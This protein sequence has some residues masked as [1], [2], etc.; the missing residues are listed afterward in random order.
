MTS[1]ILTRQL[2]SGEGTMSS[3]VLVLDDSPVLLELTTKS[4]LSV[5]VDATGALDLA[6]LDRKLSSTNFD[7]ILVDV[8]M[9]EVFGDDV[10]DFLRS[11]RRI[12]SKLVLYS[13]LPEPELA[14]KARNCAADGYICKANGLEHAV[15]DVLRMLEG[16]LVGSSSHGDANRIPEVAAKKRRVLVVDDSELTAQWLERELSSK[17]F[18]VCTADSADKATK[19]ILRKQTRPDLVLLDVKMPN[20][21]GEQL[22]RFIKGNSLF[23]GIK[24]LLCSG[25]SVEE[26]RRIC[27]ESGA[28]GYVAKDAVLGHLLARELR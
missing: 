16:S 28:D 4:L 1:S 19:I 27:R 6:E 26:L 18:E 22:C 8:K 17:G 7:L 20:V 3:R 5:G 2:R 14:E 23:A 25:E 24:V 12:Q 21:N 13:D 11:Q 9:P 15:A 10:L